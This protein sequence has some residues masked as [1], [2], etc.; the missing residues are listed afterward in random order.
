MPAIGSFGH[1]LDLNVRQGACFSFNVEIS[2]PDA[3]PVDLTGAS[4]TAMIRKLHG[5]ALAVATFTAAITLPNSIELS[6]T[7]A[8]TAAISA[9]EKVS[10]RASLY[11]W[12]M[13]ILWADGC[14]TSPLY[15]DVRIK[16]E[17]T[18]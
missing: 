6:L 3:T 15:G 12:D 17:A 18:K 4:A 2:N 13:E 14:V 7:A 5:D 10:D 16:A 8:E 11:V 1:K 9:G